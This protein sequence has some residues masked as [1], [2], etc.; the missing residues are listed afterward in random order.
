MRVTNKE[1]AYYN[2]MDAGEHIKTK[3]E[4]KTWSKRWTAQFKSKYGDNLPLSWYEEYSEL[5]DKKKEELYGN[6]IRV[7]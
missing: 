5:Y 6:G 2:F 7:C 4:F 1:K 3:E